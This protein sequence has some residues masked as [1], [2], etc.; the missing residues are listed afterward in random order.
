MSRM[1]QLGSTLSVVLAPHPLEGQQNLK[2]ESP[3][4]RENTV[5]H[6]RSGTHRRYQIRLVN[7]VYHETVPGAS[8]LGHFPT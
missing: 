6:A 3:T 7:A 2:P 8:L 1:L 5:R 4:A